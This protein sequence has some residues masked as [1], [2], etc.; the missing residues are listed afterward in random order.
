MSVTNDDSYVLFD[1]KP[2]NNNAAG[3]RGMN[4]D[5]YFAIYGNAEIRIK[6]GIKTLFSNFGVNNAF[7]N[8]RGQKVDR[9]L[10]EG[11]KREVEFEMAEFYQVI[12]EEEPTEY[13][14]VIA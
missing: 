5:A 9:F 4:Y 12:F 10:G 7:F 11:E 3:F 6:T 1:K 13:L 14:K 8:S 2:G